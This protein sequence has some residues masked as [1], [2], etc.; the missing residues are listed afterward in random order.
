MADYYRSGFEDDERRAPYATVESGGRSESRYATG[1]G[2]G[3]TYGGTA[4]GYGTTI[5]GTAGGYGNYGATGSFGGYG[6]AAGGFGGTPG[7]YGTSGGF[8][9]TTGGYG[10]TTGGYGG[11]APETTYGGSRFGATQFERHEGSRYGSSIA[12]GQHTGG[13]GTWRGEHIGERRY[14]EYS[15]R[16]Q[17]WGSQERTRYGEQGRTG[18][19]RSLDRL[20]DFGAFGQGNPGPRRRLGNREY[21]PY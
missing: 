18:I 19:G 16:T 6:A 11:H 8:G 4:G 2:Y 9:G 7:A 12:T 20:Q 5:G 15:S 3:P 21:G 13:T 17:T 1:Y 10:T 14:P